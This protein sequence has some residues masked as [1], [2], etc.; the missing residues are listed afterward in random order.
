[1]HKI[2][3]KMKLTSAAYCFEVEAARIARKA[4][5]GQFVI[6]RLD[7]A[8]ERIPLTIADFDRKEGTIRMVVQEEGYTTKKMA[9]LTEG[10][11][12]LDITGPLGKPTAMQKYEKKVILVGGGLGIAPLFPIL[13][14]LKA[15]D[16][17]AEVI[18]GARNK[19]FIFWQERF[20]EIVPR[21]TAEDG[22]G[23]HLVTDDGSLGRKGFVTDEL[24]EMLTQPVSL[25]MAIG[26]MIMM[27][28]VTQKVPEEIPTIVSMNTL[29]VDGTG[30]C[31]SCRLTVGGQTRY[32]CVDGPDFEGHTIDWDEV[33]TRNRLFEAEE[34]HICKIGL[35]KK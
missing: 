6:V 29:M 27:K 19:D 32:A 7:E 22:S 21:G 14:E 5:P 16:N 9:L 18:L 31:G 4:A 13:R 28:A 8:G 17:D 23:V 33:M 2:L 24:A 30:M 34:D 20:R 1:M 35:N 26:P 11:N 15:Q 12:V 10:D 25:V 3:K